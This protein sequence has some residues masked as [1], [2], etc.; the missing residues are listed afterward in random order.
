MSY[1]SFDHHHI[2]EYTTITTVHV[3]SNTV[4]WEPSKEETSKLEGHKPGHN[5]FIRSMFIQRIE[6][7]S[8]Y[9]RNV[10]HEVP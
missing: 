5:A 1:S 7:P 3:S 10:T 9:D 2:Y 4:T 6:G 8:E